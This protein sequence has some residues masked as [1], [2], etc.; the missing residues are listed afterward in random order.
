MPQEIKKINATTAKELDS[1]NAL[2]R[3]SDYINHTPL[4]SVPALNEA[5]NSCFSHECYIKLECMQRTGSFKIRGVLNSLLKLKS[6]N[7]L[8]QKIVTYGTG[9][10]G[11]ALAWAGFKICNIK[12]EVFL[13]KF[14]SEIKKSLIQSYNGKVVI[15]DTREEAEIK[16]TCAGNQTGCLLLPPSDNDDVIEG[17]STVALEVFNSLADVDAVFMP[18]GGGSLASG[19]LVAR[20]LFSPKS[21][22]YAAEPIMAND[23]ALSYKNGKIFRFGTTPQTMADAATALGITP[24]IFGY[25]KKLDGIYEIAE[26]EIAYWARIFAQ[27]TQIKCEPTSVLSLAAAFKYLKDQTQQQRI[28]AIITGSNVN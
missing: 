14:A 6:L 19:T 28:V 26:S 21:K 7:V 27:L 11:I 18:I 25:V 4:I 9:N 20:N 16:A 8:P 24:K 2:I 12:V 10:H 13:P 1:H 23:A 5:L 15:T 17:A 22:I 3:I